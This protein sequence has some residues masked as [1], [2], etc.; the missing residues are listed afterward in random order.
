MNSKSMDGFL[1]L[2]SLSIRVN[3]DLCVYDQKYRVCKYN[4]SVEFNPINTQYYRDLNPKIMFVGTFCRSRYA[5][6]VI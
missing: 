5:F 1:D 2:V 4:I 6:L 3:F